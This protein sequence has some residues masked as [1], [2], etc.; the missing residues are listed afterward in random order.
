[1]S[2]LTIAYFTLGKANKVSKDIDIC[3]TKVYN[4]N[5]RTDVLRCI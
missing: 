1:M 5:T 3:E 2:T 4:K